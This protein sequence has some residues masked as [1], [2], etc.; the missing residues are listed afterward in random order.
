MGTGSRYRPS[1]YFSTSGAALTDECN[2]DTILENNTW[3]HIAFTYN[4]DTKKAVIFING[5]PKKSIT[6]SGSLFETDSPLNFLAYNTPAGVN[7]NG[8]SAVGAFYNDVRITEAVRYPDE[9]FTPPT[10]FVLYPQ[11]IPE[12]Y[13]WDYTSYQMVA[14]YITNPEVDAKPFR[15]L[16]VGKNGAQV[17][18]ENS[19][20]VLQNVDP[21]A[22]HSWYFR[23]KGVSGNVLTQAF[24]RYNPNYDPEVLLPTEGPF[25]YEL[26]FRML[27]PPSS[28]DLLGEAINS[29]TARWRLKF[30]RSGGQVRFT[31]TTSGTGAVNQTSPEGIP[32]E[33]GEWCHL[34]LTRDS[35]GTLRVFFNGKLSLKIP[36]VVFNY[37][38]DALLG[39]QLCSNH[40]AYDYNMPDFDF[41][42][43][44]KL[45]DICLYGDDAGF[46]PSMAPHPIGKPGEGDP[47]W[48]DV[49]FLEKCDNRSAH[50]AS[51]KNTRV[52]G[53]AQATTSI[54]TDL[55]IVKFGKR[56]RKSTGFSNALTAPEYPAGA[57]KLNGKSLTVEYWTYLNF[58][59]PPTTGFRGGITRGTTG[60][61]ASWALAI[62]NAATESRAACVLVTSGG[63]VILNSDPL[64]FKQWVHLAMSYDAEDPTLRLFVNGIKVGETAITDPI[65]DPDVASLTMFGGWSGN[66]GLPDFHGDEFRITHALRYTEDFDPPT[67]SFPTFKLF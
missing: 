2:S 36:N 14:D 19:N 33:L 35:Q 64:P 26:L 34:A 60:V 51:S 39:N 32:V 9:G 63:S 57:L 49:V 21:P 40:S 54:S 42:N 53:A 55:D 58:D 61:T 38:P 50:P 23:R 66:A 8:R 28:C 31:F 27:A 47:L 17:Y 59:P 18:W 5:E 22:G 52:V 46:T 10:K 4:E 1:A 43:L 3:Y 67:E 30:S 62:N 7:V 13:Y 56:S 11:S 25:T 29:S 6:V 20:T 12:W 44:R 65:V 41:T 45:S 37:N 16:P 48:D 15:V 24:G